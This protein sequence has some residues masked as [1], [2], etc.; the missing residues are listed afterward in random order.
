MN[1]ITTFL[2]T[3]PDTCTEA[4]L[5]F[6]G[7]LESL[8]TADIQSLVVRSIRSASPAAAW[9]ANI[10]FVVL[11]RRL[12]HPEFVSVCHAIRRAAA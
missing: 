11:A 9:S 8:P 10:A 3:A 12:D 4:G 7:I 2:A 1:A 5:A 6:D